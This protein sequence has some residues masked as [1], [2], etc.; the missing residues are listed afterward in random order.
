MQEWFLI[1][2]PAFTIG[3]LHTFM[4]C[5][6]KAIFLFWSFGISKDAKSSLLI[7]SLYGLGLIGANLTLAIVTVLLTF[8]PR[9]FGFIPQTYAINFFGAFSSI[10]AA[11]FLLF[12]IM[13]R[14]YA[15]H[16]HYKDDL[17]S[18]NWEK[19]R[20]PFLFGML[21]GYPPCIFELFIYSQCFTWSLSYG[22]LEG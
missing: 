13:R 1:L 8:I 21:A 3:I 4:P 12:F 7:L 20:T 22:F 16:D 15:P 14:D 19:K 2:L 11:I 18:L 9:F 5:E 17:M 10:F 6:D